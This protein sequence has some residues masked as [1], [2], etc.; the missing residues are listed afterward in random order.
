MRK[1]NFEVFGITDVG[2][3]K[4][5]NQDSF[6]YKVVEAGDFCYGIFAVADGVGGLENGE[7]ASSLAISNIN[8]W[9][10]ND[11]K[12]N[13]NNYDYLINTLIKTLKDANEKIIKVAESKS[14]KMAT[15][16]SVLF[17]YKNNYFIIHIGDSRIYKLSNNFG[18][19]IIQLTEDHSQ[20]IQ[21]NYNG[22]LVQKSVLTQCLGNRSQISHFCLTDKIKKNDYFLL[23]SDGIYKTLSNENIFS[24]FKDNAKDINQVCI[25]L[26]ES[27]KNNNEKDNISVILVRITD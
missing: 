1:L 11:F 20:I 12:N 9:W 13:V 21:K 18:T 15:T 8:K 22:K 10:E 23:C 19:K 7:V 5:I 16:L 6:V 14:C 4:Q 24:I 17:L 26:I 25:R 2:I 27:A 3:E